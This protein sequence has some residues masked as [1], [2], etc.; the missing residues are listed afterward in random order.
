MMMMQPPGG[1]GSIL[2]CPWDAEQKFP[3]ICSVR[4]C[5]GGQ[6]M[7]GHATAHQH[8]KKKRRD[9]DSV[10]PRGASNNLDINIPGQIDCTCRHQG[11]RKFF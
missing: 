1:G 2:P 10:D 7:G 5:G 6:L 8:W 11:T 9:A 3:N 4:P